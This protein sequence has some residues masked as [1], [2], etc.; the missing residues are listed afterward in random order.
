MSILLDSLRQKDK[1]QQVPVPDIHAY[2]FDD[3]DLKTENDNNNQTKLWRVLAFILLFL[4]L[5][6]SL[7]YAYKLN[8]SSDQLL[9]NPEKNISANPAMLKAV[10]PSV[11]KSAMGTQQTSA[12]STKENI[13]KEKA[14]A[15]KVSRTQA[16][17]N[18]T[19]VLQRHVE[20]RK[21]LEQEKQRLQ[22]I[23]DAQRK[24]SVIRTAEA[25]K[26][27]QQVENLP[28]QVKNQEQAVEFIDAKPAEISK[29]IGPAIAW[30]ELSSDEK[31]Q[32]PQLQIGSYVISDNPHKSFVIM[33]NRFYKINQFITPD[34]ILRD[35]TTGYIVVE[36][37]NK[38]VNVPL[39]NN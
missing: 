16:E 21:W 1:E 34:L 29:E 6:S 39:K 38:L 37:N 10:K 13:R 17:G 30:Q 23:K 14:P 27:Q 8:K 20:E 7:Y 28:S 19:N 26:S 35:I 25:I 2:H 32:F 9:G 5:V 24:Q 3:E 12:Q 31:K 4:F 18:K 33:Q 15:L 11:K 36:F 22:A